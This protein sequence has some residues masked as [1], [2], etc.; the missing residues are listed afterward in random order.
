MGGVV[1]IYCIAVVITPS[2]LASLQCRDGARPVFTEQADIA[3]TK[4][5]RAAAR[6]RQVHRRDCGCVILFGGFSFYRSYFRVYH[7]ILQTSLLYMY[8][9]AASSVVCTC[10]PLAARMLHWFTFIFRSLF[11]FVF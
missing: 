4:C 5:W 6:D 9:R 1:P 8:V 7:E 11:P 3:C 10:A 2:T